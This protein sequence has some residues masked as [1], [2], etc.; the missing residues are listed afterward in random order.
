M[1]AY[2]RSVRCIICCIVSKS[3]QYKPKVQ[4]LSVSITHVWLPS[5]LDIAEE[6]NKDNFSPDFL[7]DYPDA[8]EDISLNLPKPYGK[9]LQTSVFFDADHAHDQKTRRSVSGIF[10]F[11]GSTPV[12]WSSKRQGCVA[13]S[14]Y[15]AE[16]ISTRTAVEEAI[17]IRYYLRC[18]GIPVRK[19]T[20]VFGD[21]FSVIQSATL[22][23][24]ELKKK[25]IAISSHY[26][27]E[28]IAARIV[29]AVWIATDDNFADLNTKPLGKTKFR[30]FVDVLMD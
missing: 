21:N 26:V 28:A 22:V 29:N 1:G 2:Y 4:S 10:V 5:P 19:P 18:L 3:I 24:G 7:E 15:T 9:E 11:V 16:F 6:Y 20:N 27:R 30:E 8:S 13:T 14:T 12:I 25:H 23:D 17:A